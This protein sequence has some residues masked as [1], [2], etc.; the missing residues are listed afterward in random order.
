MLIST[1]QLYERCL[2]AQESEDP[3]VQA[4]ARS[5]MS[6]LVV[7][8]KKRYVVLPPELEALMPLLPEKVPQ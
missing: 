8:L 2:L 1:L 4:A 5:L 3:E 6:Y 7:Y